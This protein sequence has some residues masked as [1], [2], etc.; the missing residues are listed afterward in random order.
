VCSSDLEQAG[1]G[2]L[3]AFPDLGETAPAPEALSAEERTA[4]SGLIERIRSVLGDRIKDVRIS[5]RLAGSPAVLASSDGISSSME[6]LLRVMQKSDE[7]PNKI[8]E[9]NPNHHL[10]RSLLRIHARDPENP[11]LADLVRG[12]FDNVLLLD[13]Y[14]HEP[15]LVADRALKLMDAAAGWY[16]DLLHAR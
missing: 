3:D 2:D 13:G 14:L 9:I 4:L 16:A 10:L 5:D 11:L 7:I 15:H 12:L 6:K 1:A 8:L